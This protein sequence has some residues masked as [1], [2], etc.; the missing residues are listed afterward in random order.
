MIGGRCAE[1]L[2]PIFLQASNFML[3]AHGCHDVYLLEVALRWATLHRR[4]PGNVFAWKQLP[5]EYDGP[6]APADE[7]FPPIADHFDVDKES[8]HS[9]P[10]QQHSTPT[11]EGPEIY[12]ETSCG[13]SNT[14]VLPMLICIRAPSGLLSLTSKPI[15]MKTLLDDETPNMTEALTTNLLRIGGSEKSKN[16]SHELLVLL[17]PCK[18]L[19]LLS[20]SAPV[21]R[22]M[23]PLWSR[24]PRTALSWLRFGCPIVS[25][26]NPGWRPPGAL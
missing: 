14:Y 6:K 21:R 7:N 17:C 12:L 2:Q 19:F 15:A 22:T 11:A 26:P 10:L 16:A 24:R 18:L 25:R 4:T 9:L 13:K 8:Q 5:I 23:Q 1:T 3:T 20:F